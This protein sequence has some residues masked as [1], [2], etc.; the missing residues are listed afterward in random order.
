ML[1]FYLC[2]LTFFPIISFTAPINIK[3]AIKQKL[4]H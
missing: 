2:K 3:T 4:I 1:S